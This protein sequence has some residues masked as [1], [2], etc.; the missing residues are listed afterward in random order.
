MA[1][2]TQNAPIAQISQALVDFTLNGSFPEENVSSLA[3]QP[4][5][6]PEAIKALADAKAKLQAEVHAINEETADDVRAWQTNAQSVQDDMLRSK[7]L[8]NEIIKA[9]EA[10]AVSGKSLQEAEA[11][12]AFLVRELNY[13]AQVQEALKGIRTVNRTLDEVE[14]ARNE[15]RILDALHLLERSWNELDA[16]PVSKSCRAVKLLDIRA[17]E[18]KSDVHEVF[19]HVWNTLI[20]VDIV[21]HRVSI[22]SSRQDE[23]MNL[24]DAVIGLQAYKE[25]DQRMNQLWQNI[26][27]AVLAPRMDIQQP[28]LPGIHIAD[29]VM[30]LQGSSDKSVKSL[31]TDLEQ[32]FSFL[33]KTLPP[34][35]VET[36]SSTLLPE[37]I[38]RITC[39]WLDSAVPSSLNDMEKFQ[40]VIALAKGFCGT[41]RKLGFSNLG[42]LQE[43]TDSAPRVWLSKCREAALDSIR[44]KLSQGLG[45]PTRVEKIEKQ[46]VSRSEGQQLTASGA[47]AS[48][49]DD[50]GWGDAWDDGEEDASQEEQTATGAKKAPEDG[51][52][53]TDAWG[54]GDE[55]ADEEELREATKKTAQEEDDDPTA[56]WGWGDEDT[57]ETAAAANPKQTNPEQPATR[58]LTLKESYSIS[59]L[60]YPVLELISTIAEDGAA[61]TQDS[62]ANSPVAAAAA[63]LFSVPTLALAMFRAISPHYYSPIPGGNMYLYND[64][65]YLSE[66]LSD[67]ASGW[68]TRTD[69]SKRAQT[70]LRLDNDVKSLRAFANRA[71]TNELTL[72]KSI[73]R[74]HLGSEQNLLQQDDAESSVSLA[75][76]R[77]RSM[78]LTWESIL[79]R[80]VWQQAVGSLI[81]ALASKIIGDVMDLPSI[82]Q[83]EAYSIA[84]LIASV[85]ELDDLFLPSK[86]QG[87]GTPKKGEI[88]VTSQ[89][90]SLWLR[91]KY[92][93]EV[94]QSNL[95]DVRFLWMEGELSLYFTADEVVDLVNASF[96]EN[97]RTKE[98]VREIRGNPHPRGGGGE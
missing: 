16:I 93:S 77:V 81:D 60:P 65:T 34:D 40:E 15:R 84:K 17:F 72:Q 79:S 67:F 69:I 89:F 12:A 8:A 18:L 6:L 56:A 68:K 61:L 76:S 83:E 19:D 78:A 29:N 94:L 30:G 26:S 2:A 85:E 14:Q 13:N 52:D 36:I 21:N 20:N 53:G 70:M 33:V 80:S 24:P 10:P 59:S 1:A 27:E 43:W 48:A 4:E 28:T 25:V 31:F 3:L 88:P 37:V 75:V 35:L 46:M 55:A 97:V 45:T 82:G 74:D 39:V 73:L 32:V 9:S 57:N 62:Y 22:S 95:R 41:L 98:V 66:K 42:D 64:V 7:A 86:L 87:F 23:P 47:T 96:E 44:T 63:G 58:E 5:A 38:H 92:L 90:A 91:L 71:Y 11:K 51:D 54:W 50:H 49:D